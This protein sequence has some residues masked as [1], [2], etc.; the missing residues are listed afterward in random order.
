MEGSGTAEEG[1]RGVTA[2]PRRRAI[3]LPILVLGWFAVVACILVSLLLRFDPSSF[4]S[5]STFNLAGPE[6]NALVESFAGRQ[7]ARD[8]AIS[9]VLAFALAT[10]KARLVGY[11]FVLWTLVETQDFLQGLFEVLS[12]GLPASALAT[13]LPTLVLISLYALAALTL[14]RRAGTAD[15]K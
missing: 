7:S 12:G 2:P 5:S 4:A 6:V 13:A 3:P 8:V 14:F 9:L 15:A 1:K 11:L 10:G